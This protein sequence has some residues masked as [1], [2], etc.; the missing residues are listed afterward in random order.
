MTMF[1]GVEATAAERAEPRAGDELVRDADVVMD[2]ALTVPGAPADVWPWVVQLGKGRAGWYLPRSVER[3]IPRRRRAARDVD[4]RWQQVSVGDVIPDYGQRDATFTVA[5]LRPPTTL[6]YRST[7][8]RMNVSWSI[9]LRP[10]TTTT[11]G[12]G[13]RMLLRLRLGPVRRRWLATSGG[14]L[15][16]RITISGLAAGLRERLTTGQPP[17]Q[18]GD[19]AR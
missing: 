9:V 17:A 6:V 14:E 13:T 19:D 16:D 2:R 5:E 18:G 15:I 7:R 12:D 1:S 4:P 8:G 3:V 11:A 10:T